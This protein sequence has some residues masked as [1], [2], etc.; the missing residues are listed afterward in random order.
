MTP[1]SFCLPSPLAPLQVMRW[2]DATYLEDQDMWRLRC[3]RAA[4]GWMVA[5]NGI[6][7]QLQVLACLLA[8]SCA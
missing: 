5:F 2:S 8:E 4:P 7:C 3:A 1:L 6:G